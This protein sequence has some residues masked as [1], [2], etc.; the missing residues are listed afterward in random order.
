MSIFK[1]QIEEMVYE[2][3]HLRFW[4]TRGAFFEMKSGVSRAN[5]VQKWS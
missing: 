5:G 1:D 2:I 4:Y 3:R